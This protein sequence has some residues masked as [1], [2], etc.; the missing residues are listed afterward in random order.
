[1]TYQYL[2]YLLKFKENPFYGGLSAWIGIQ[3][4][5]LK[6][7]IADNGAPSSYNFKKL[8]S[9][10]RVGLLGF[11]LR[12]L[13]LGFQMGLIL[14]LFSFV[15]VLYNIFLYFY[16]KDVALGFTSIVSL[17]TMLFGV[18]FIFLGLLG[19][20]LGDVFIMTKNRPLYLIK[21]KINVE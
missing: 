20:Y 8:L 7:N 1:M 19:E 14:I 5:F 10:A 3:P 11:S 13:R 12:P 18:Q 2:N 9:H 6:I 16:S 15:F 4:T 17:I 21:E